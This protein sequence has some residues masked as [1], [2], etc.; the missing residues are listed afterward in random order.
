M[1]A[2]SLQ[3]QVLQNSIV[4]IIQKYYDVWMINKTLK[5]KTCNIMWSNTVKRQS[6]YNDQIIQISKEKM[7]GIQTRVRADFSARWNI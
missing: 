5:I 3:L 4:K 2:V 7:N 1:L 6:K